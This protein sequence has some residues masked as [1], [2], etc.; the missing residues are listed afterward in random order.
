MYHSN[1]SKEIALLGLA[2]FSLSKSNPQ[3]DL[4]NSVVNNVVAFVD[5]CNRCCSI[6]RMWSLHLEKALEDGKQ[7]EDVSILV[8]EL[9]RVA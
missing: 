5:L 7:S 1:E 9:R 3:H 2:V 4:R 6:A 8:Q